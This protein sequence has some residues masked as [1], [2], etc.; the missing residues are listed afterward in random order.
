MTLAEHLA[1]CA[2]KQGRSFI[3]C[4]PSLRSAS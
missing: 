3:A 4:V 1:S 2:R